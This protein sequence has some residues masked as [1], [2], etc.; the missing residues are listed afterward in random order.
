[1]NTCWLNKLRNENKKKERRCNWY[2]TRFTYVTKSIFIHWLLPLCLLLLLAF[3][4]ARFTLARSEITEKIYFTSFFQ[5]RFDF[6]PRFY[7]EL[8]EFLEAV[9]SLLL[10]FCSPEIDDE[11]SRNS[12]CKSGWNTVWANNKEWRDM[13]EISCGKDCWFE[14][15][16]VFGLNFLGL[17]WFFLRNWEQ[18]REKN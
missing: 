13:N 18:K 11:R 7:M 5:L 6:T 15:F 16:S 9:W 4:L 3:S 14:D 12:Q 2:W 17:N 10:T 8:S 1:M